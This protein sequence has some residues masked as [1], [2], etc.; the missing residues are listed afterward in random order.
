MKNK[1]TQEKKNKNMREKKLYLTPSHKIID[2]I[3]WDSN[4]D[5][6]DL[7]IGYIDRFDGLQTID[8]EGF[9]EAEIPGHR[10]IWLKLKNNLVWDREKKLDLINS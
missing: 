5:I 1:P 3:K 2:R 4:F 7:L 8:M 10:I 9:E 6:K